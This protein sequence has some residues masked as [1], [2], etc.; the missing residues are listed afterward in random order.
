LQTKDSKARR[1]D[2]EKV[3][4]RHL[5]VTSGTATIGFIDGEG[6][7]FTAT[8]IAGV[9]L[10]VFASVKAAANAISDAHWVRQ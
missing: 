3:A 2:Q 1:S 9:V 7:R 10:G 4:R 5:T 6:S 8:A